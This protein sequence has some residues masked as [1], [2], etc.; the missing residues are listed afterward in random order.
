V[1]GG[2]PALHGSLKA[3]GGAAKIAVER[4][5]EAQ[6][7]FRK[8]YSEALRSWGKEGGGIGRCRGAVKGDRE[9]RLVPDLQRHLH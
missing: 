8:K 6:N 2:V 5:A 4:E 9:R 3:R 7:R 1:K